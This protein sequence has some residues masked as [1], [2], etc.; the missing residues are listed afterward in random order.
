MKDYTEEMTPPPLPVAGFALLILLFTF[1]SGFAVQAVWEQEEREAYTESVLQSPNEQ[2][3]KLRDR[4]THRREV[5]ILIAVERHHG[6]L[7]E[8]FDQGAVL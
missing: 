2:L 1:A 6:H 8:V 4:R 3:A 5:G 7:L